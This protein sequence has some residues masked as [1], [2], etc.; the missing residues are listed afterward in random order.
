[1]VPIYDTDTGTGISI[2]LFVH[3][4]G[5]NVYRTCMN[6][7]SV[8]HTS[9]SVHLTTTNPRQNPSRKG[10]ERTASIRIIIIVIRLCWNVN[11]DSTISPEL[12]CAELEALATHRTLALTERRCNA[13]NNNGRACT[14]AT[15]TQAE[16]NLLLFQFS[17]SPSFFHV[18]SFISLMH[19]NTRLIC[20]SGESEDLWSNIT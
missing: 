19:T 20:I 2:L 7:S 11:V 18:H 15:T 12:N 5:V 4:R 9:F 8:C 16:Q 13:C 3:K 6:W 1:M 14:A 10:D 17:L